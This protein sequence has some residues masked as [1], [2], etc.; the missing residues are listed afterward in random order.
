MFDGTIRLSHGS[1]TL[2]LEPCD[3]V[4]T[5]GN[6]LGYTNDLVDEFYPAIA[7]LPFGGV[8]VGQNPTLL[9]KFEF[10]LLLT[11]EKAYAMQALIL[12]LK[13]EI[14]NE[15]QPAYITMVDERVPIL[16]QSPRLRAR[17]GP[18]L[19]DIPL[20][21]GFTRYYPIYAVNLSAPGLERN[22]FSPVGSHIQQIVTGNEL[23]LLPTTFDQP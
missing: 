11:L 9:R 18:E 22:L 4:S 20:P 10:D 23:L 17:S 3:F 6:I 15:V 8:S 5:D 19:T 14:Q 1:I 21:V 12:G 7:V 13:T 2:S 16:E